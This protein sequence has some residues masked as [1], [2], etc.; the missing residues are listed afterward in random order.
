[1]VFIGQPTNTTTGAV[2]T[3]PVQV[4]IE[5]AAGRV[6]TNA[7][8]QI[9]LSFL[10]NPGGATLSGGGATNPV[11]GIAAFSNLSL[12]NVGTGYTLSAT[13]AP[14]LNTPS[15]GPFSVT[16][17]PATVSTAVPFP[18]FAGDLATPIAITV[19]NDSAGDALTATLTVDANTTFN[20]T[21]ATCGTIGVVTGTPGSGNYTVSY[22]PPASTSAF[23]QTVPTIVVTSNLAG[24]IGA[25]DFIEVDPAGILVT[26]DPVAKQGAVYIGANPADQ[27]TLNVTVYN[28]VTHQGATIAPLTASGDA[29]GSL[30]VNSC[31]LLGTPSAPTF[32][33]STATIT[34]PYTPPASLPAAPYDKPSVKAVS[35]A[36]NTRFG[37]TAFRLRNN[38]VAGGPSSTMWISRNTMFRTALIGTAQTL[39]ARV[40]NDTG[41]N[42]TVNWM[43]TAGG[44]NCSPACGTLGAATTSVNATT[45]NSFITYTPPSSVPT[46]ASAQPIITATSADNSSQND[47]FTFNIIDGTCGTGHES[48][49]NG[50]YAF[51]L[52]GGAAPGGYLTLIGSFTADGTGKI[53]GGK[54][55]GNT[56]GFGPLLD[57]TILTAPMG[58]L[59]ASSY[60]VGADNRGCLTLTD[61][62]GGYQVFRFSLGTVVN[63]VATE[64]RIIKFDDNTW[65]G[66][67]QAGVLMKQDPT[68]FNAGALSGTYAFGVAGV[69]L[70]G[71][72]TAAAGVFTANGAGTLSNLSEDFDSVT[73]PSG[74]LT[75]SGS[76]TMTASGRGT[77][78]L[79]INVPGG[80]ATSHSVLYMVSSSE[81]L[82]MTT[83]TLGSNTPGS[84][85]SILS[86]EAKKQTGPFTQTAL[87]GNSY[88]FSTVGLSNSDGS[89]QATM[90]RITL[91]T[92][93]STTN[94]SFSGVI[95]DNGNPE[96]TPSGTTLIGTNGRMT[97]PTGGGGNPPIFY[98]VNSSLAFIVDT[99]NSVAFGSFEQQTGP[100]GTASITG[101][102]FFGAE[103]PTTGSSYSSGAATFTPATGVITGTE[104]RSASDGLRANNP[105]S[106]N[107]GAAVTYCFAPST[108]T[109]P[110]TATG[111]GN[112]GG[113]LAY[114][115]SASKIIF[116][117]TGNQNGGT[118]PVNRNFVVIQK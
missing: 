104:D 54:S 100:F 91:T 89:N 47:S 31:G 37:S 59:P 80:T 23:I 63:N 106:N 36:D 98:F 74:V 27:R 17:G 58:S 43:L 97:L 18:I 8:N 112:V 56:T 94:G 71:G 22:T 39:T 29:C 45:V 21:T 103:A 30:S 108:C 7:T 55:D 75:G 50:Q 26:V 96:S 84:N 101:P 38:P 116:M 110:T 99:S 70:N 19:A 32:V 66:R 78:T 86:G 4:A 113:S 9:T 95:D 41:P 85:T 20:C 24:S 88:I 6:V 92:S 81:I 115:I 65:R 73:A 109:P 105:I 114:I 3:P 10:N 83:D 107:G 13:S 72:R 33:G 42:L 52:R 68:S 40:L 11:N 64:G 51:L 35:V 53:T 49:L 117:D 118:G 79:T 15:S 69:D 16:T 62:G 111:Q 14:A 87:N 77:S 48:V 82:L 34:V 90:G 61:T 44:V 5:D 60:S 25:T 102:Y 46:G 93:G 1:L 76:S 12:N 2:I 57:L 28:D 67:S